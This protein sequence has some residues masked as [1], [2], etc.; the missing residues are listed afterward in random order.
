MRIVRIDLDRQP[1]IGR[2]GEK[3]VTQIVIDANCFAQEYP[4]GTPAMLFQRNGDN[5]PYPLTC[6]I[7]ERGF[8][9]ATIGA[10]ETEKHGTARVQLDWYVGDA[11]KKS[12]VYR[13]WV[14]EDIGGAGDPPAQ[15]P[16]WVQDVLD[17]GTAVL[18][19]MPEIMEAIAEKQDTL[20]AG[21]NITIADD[22]KTI[23]AA[24]GGTFDHTQLTNRDAADQHPMTAVT[25]LVSALDEKGTYSKPSGGIPA[26]DL[27][28][29][30]N[31]ALDDAVTAVQPGDLADVATSGDYD[32]LSN[33][34]TIPEA[35]DDTAIKNRLAAIEAQEETWNDK[36]DAISDLAD[37]RNGAA[38][39]ATAVQT[40]T[41]PTVPSWAKQ[42]S[43]PTYTAEEVGALPENTE[44]PSKTSDLQNDSGYITTETDPTVPAW[45]KNAT[46]PTYDA[47]E[48]AYDPE[49]EEHTEG[50]V[51][52][53]LSEQYTA[54]ANLD[55]AAIKGVKVAGTELTKDEN[56]K[57][58]VPVASSQTKGVV[59]IYRNNG[60]DLDADGNLISVS[61]TN[62]QIAGKTSTPRV[63]VPGLIDHAI[64]AGLLSNAQITS[65]DLPSIQQTLG[66]WSGT[67]AE[68]DAIA[69]K[70]AN[71][72]YM[73][74]EA[75]T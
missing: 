57:V 61:A 40:E 10:L 9:T 50:S 62:E 74:V 41:D 3:N 11:L 42:T 47:E 56:G 51:A 58:N 21:E 5:A 15:R 69:V 6:A 29:A 43:K 30:V 14:D 49:A 64:R 25:G 20:I 19:A 26:S 17:A 31:A 72:I 44:I 33:K 70:D 27:S 22:G 37:I 36:Q 23:S 46:K 12:A 68:Y 54:I 45:A 7:D 38:A 52:A 60:V 13:A 2:R 71:V 8:V 55:N 75:S 53:E 59:G 4:G 32:D 18:E 63:L 66:I 34:P 1:P 16:D 73:I 28:A 67:Q 39:G 24:S 65:S 48:I 35:Y